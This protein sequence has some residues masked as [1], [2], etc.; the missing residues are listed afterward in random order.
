M[1][2]SMAAFELNIERRRRVAG[3]KRLAA[4][5]GNRDETEPVMGKPTGFMEFTREPPADPSAGADARS[6]RSSTC[7]FAE[8]SCTQQ[9]ARCMD[10][11][12]PFCHTGQLLNGMASGCPINNLIPEWNDLVY[13]GLWQRGARAPAQDQQFPG[14]HRPRLPGAVRRLLHAGH[15]RPAGDDQEHRVRHHRQGL[16]GRLDRARTARG[17]HRQEGGRGRLRPV[18]AGAAPR[19]STGPGTA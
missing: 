14:I 9:G 5:P 12:I 6:G 13:R 3:T 1:K 18:R 15:Q 17:A 4:S 11:G 8:R 10:C 19:S 2:R 7:T 16:R